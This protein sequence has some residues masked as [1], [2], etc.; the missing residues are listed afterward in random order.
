VSATI[1]EG[2]P[3]KLL[4]R[5]IERRFQIVTSEFILKELG[6]VL[7]RPRFNMSEDEISRVVLTLMQSSDL[8]T[9]TSDFNVV[10]NDP[11]D[12]I[13][14]STAYDGGADIIVTGDRH[15]LDLE[16]FKQIRILTIADALKLF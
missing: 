15:L 11:A 10:E 2:K 7:R 6:I 9:T 1:S 13:I 4:N 12:N 5:G 8:A 14:L 3:R 16:R